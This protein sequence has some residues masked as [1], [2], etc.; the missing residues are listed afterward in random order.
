MDSN[1]PFSYLVKKELSQLNNL[2]NKNLVKFELEGYLLP[3]SSS[4]VL[5]ENEYNINRFAKLLMNL[6]I[7]N[8]DVEMKGDN[9][10]LIIKDIRT[11]NNKYNILNENNISEEEAKAVFRGTFLRSGSV[12]NP[13]NVY[14]LEIIFEDVKR[15]NFFIDLA[16]K[17]N[18]DFGSSK[19]NSGL[20]LYLKSG[21]SISEFLAFIGCN[22]S[23]LNFE[24]VR[25]VKE[26]RNNVNRQVNLEA[27][28]MNKT[29]MSSVKQIND[30][31]YIKQMNCFNKLS[32]KEKI[33]SDL[34]LNNPEKTL[35]ELGEMVNPPISKSGVNHRFA[36]ISKLAEELREEGK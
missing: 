14:H 29:A 21:D 8:F 17:Y 9:F 4:Q 32:E 18:F 31:K 35:A 10:C 12:N 11:L 5:T 30:I 1:K 27:A 23:V 26:I 20:M 34:R 6:G 25:M 7:E 36:N 15:G 19:R 33:L 22:S 24:D 2:K 28:N 16:K 3:N 13:N